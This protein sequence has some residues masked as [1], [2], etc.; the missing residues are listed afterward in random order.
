MEPRQQLTAD[1]L[2]RGLMAAIAKTGPTTLHGTRPQIH[3]A[4]RKVL[5]ALQESRFSER[6]NVDT[7]DIY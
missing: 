5:D 4:F 1:Q 3:G 7:F 6:L 2:F